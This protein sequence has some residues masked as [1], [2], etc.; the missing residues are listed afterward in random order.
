MKAEGVLCVLLILFL[1]GLAPAKAD[2]LQDAIRAGDL[3][4]VKALVENNPAVVHVRNSSGQTPLFDAILENRPEI[5]EYLLSKGADVNARNGFQVTPLQVLDVFPPRT[6]FISGHGRDLTY[7][8]LRK[9]R[10]AL[11]A[12]T[13]VIRKNA[14][15]MIKEDVLRDYKA[16]CSFLDWLGPDAW[17][18][19]VWNSLKGAQTK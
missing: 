13:T 16:E 12:M 6:V 15:D 3:A 17:I 18:A 2:D 14:D 7:E 5:A 1:T 10:N 4:R 9:Y 11:A 19:R 8:G